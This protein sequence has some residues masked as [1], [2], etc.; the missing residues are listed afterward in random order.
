MYMSIIYHSCK[1]CGTEKVLI[2]ENFKPEHRT[3]LGFDR[4]CRECRKKQRRIARQ[5][6]R[7]HYLQKDAEYRASDRYK[8]YHSEYQEK[9][10]ERLSELARDRYNKN[11]PSYL[12]RSKNQKKKWGKRYSEYQKN[13]RKKNRERLNEYVVNKLHTDINFKLKHLLRSK[14]RKLLNGENKTNSALTYLGGSIDFFKGYIEAKFS[15]GM[16]WE[17]YGT[18]WHIDHIIPCRSFDMSNEDDRKKC[19]HY[20]NMQPLLVIDNLQKLDILPNGQ[21]ARHVS[22]KNP[23]SA[24]NK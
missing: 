3:V 12:I 5:K 9:N 18:T 2:K 14:L 10:Q 13:Y 15:N 23:K 22:N 11:K 21:Y 6:N 1:H 16:T 4:T 20:S 19:F 24:R 8:K 7:E 17:N